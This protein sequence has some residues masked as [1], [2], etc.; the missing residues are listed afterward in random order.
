MSEPAT[1]ETSTK[2][3]N[4]SATS[5]TET[6]TVSPDCAKPKYAAEVVAEHGERR[7][8]R[9]SSPT[10][11][12][13][14]S[15]ALFAVVG[16]VDVDGDR[17]G[18]RDARQADRDGVKSQVAPVRPSGVDRDRRLRRRAPTTSPPA[19]LTL[20]SSMSTLMLSPSASTENEP[21][22]SLPSTPSTTFSPP[23]RVNDGPRNVER[24]R[25]AADDE[26]ARDVRARRVEL[27]R[28]R[29]GER[30][31][32]DAGHRGRAGRVE[33]V[34]V[35]VGDEQDEPRAADGDLNAV[36]RADGDVET[37]RADEDLRLVVRGARKLVVARERRPLDREA[38]FECEVAD[39]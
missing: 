25:D 12:A 11:T 17:A 33:R 32:G 39:G 38:A 27:Q 35:V 20:A 15:F 3:P 26:L 9:R 30:E 10:E 2:L 4:E 14:E 36:V 8:V 24:A 5:L 37:G 29:A 13:N 6:V 22:I 34:V 16:V 28:D 23:K 21:A 7:V 31:A 18:E 1:V 19:R